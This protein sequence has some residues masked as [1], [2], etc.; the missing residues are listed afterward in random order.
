MGH[1]LE[2]TL[3]FGRSTV[4][5]I[6]AR[7]QSETRTSIACLDSFQMTFFIRPMS[8]RR[9]VSL[10]ASHSR[11]LS[12]TPLVRFPRALPSSSGLKASPA[13]TTTTVYADEQFDGD[14]D[15]MDQYEAPAPKL[16]KSEKKLIRSEELRRL[17]LL[18]VSSKEKS[19][20]TTNAL[21]TQRDPYAP[22]AEKKKK[23]KK[24]TKLEKFSKDHI[25]VRYVPSHVTNERLKEEIEAKGV[26][27]KDVRLMVYPRTDGRYVSRGYGWV[28]LMKERDINRVSMLDQMEIDEIPIS[29][30]I[31][32]QRPAGSF[33][34][35]PKPI[36]EPEPGFYLRHPR[37]SHTAYLEGPSE[38]Y[39]D[40]DLD[41]EYGE[42]PTEFN[43][44]NDPSRPSYENIKYEDIRERRAPASTLAKRLKADGPR[45]G[46]REIDWLKRSGKLSMDLPAPA[47]SADYGLLGEIEEKPELIPGPE[48]GDKKI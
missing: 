12:F 34:R 9:A 8:M 27:V 31:M 47:S 24:K 15:E 2:T 11:L 48:E 29:V 39:S 42:V 43:Y 32:K 23:K 10:T 26:P 17:G 4:V 20:A 38:P 46:E 37:R 6:I 1:S 16:N 28:S 5:Q 7:L 14:Y 41:G 40:S 44:V 19:A 35:P 21:V 25:F 18:G 3:S 22:P 45:P 36:P 13:A 30:E 33:D